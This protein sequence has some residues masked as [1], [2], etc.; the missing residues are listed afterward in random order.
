LERFLYEVY[1]PGQ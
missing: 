1:R